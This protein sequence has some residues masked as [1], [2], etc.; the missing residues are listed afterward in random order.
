MLCDDLHGASRADSVPHISLSKRKVTSHA[1]PDKYPIRDCY[2][3]PFSFPFF[4]NFSLLFCIESTSNRGLTGVLDLHY[5]SLL[6]SRSLS[7]KL[8]PP[9]EDLGIAGLSQSPSQDASLT[10][11]LNGV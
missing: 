5:Y 6:L 4:D 8:L 2:L 7:S 10:S 11:H 1:E 9:P 3:S